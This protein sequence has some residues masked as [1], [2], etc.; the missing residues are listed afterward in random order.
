[1]HPLS[2]LSKG[3]IVFPYPSTLETL[4]AFG[5]VF[6]LGLLWGRI[7]RGFG[8]CHPVPHMEQRA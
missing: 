4:I 1:M 8:H 6:L 2:V 7:H 5:V 3:V